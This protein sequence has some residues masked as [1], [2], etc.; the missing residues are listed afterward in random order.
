M[1]ALRARAERG[2]TM[3]EF[4][5]LS[6]TVLLLLTVC[7]LDAGRAI[8]AYNSVSAAAR[9][10][11]RWASIVG[12]T[13][14]VPYAVSTSD[15]CN[16]FGSYPAGVAQ[17][18]N[19]SG[20]IPLQGAGTACPSYNSAPSD[21]YSLASF[22]GLQASTVVGAIAHR[23]DTSS[24]SSGFGGNALLPGLSP[25]NVWVCLETSGSTPISPGM[26]VRVVVAY[27]FTYV[28]T[29]SLSTIPPSF[30]NQTVLMTASSQGEVE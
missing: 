5:L 16:Q 3:V 1:T 8:F 27:V 7:V 29:P 28:I 11:A 24:A 23:F 4:A 15:Y 10:G 2:Q 25:G 17:F 9:Y 21:Y 19:E 14:S 22:E 18:W 30:S 20:N 12:G 26:R 13:C 6:S